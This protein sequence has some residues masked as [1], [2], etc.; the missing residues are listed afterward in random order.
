MNKAYNFSS[1][2]NKSVRGKKNDITHSVVRQM[3]IQ[4]SAIGCHRHHRD[5]HHHHHRHH[6]Y[7]CCFIEQEGNRKRLFR[8]QNIHFTIRR[9][10][11]IF[12]IMRALYAHISRKKIL[13]KRQLTHS[14]TA[15]AAAATT[16][17]RN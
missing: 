1:Y 6:H 15:A 4:N 5:H 17:G 14:L 3:S 12:G 9:V 10:S 13:V 8:I 11:A 7:C 2:G 16:N